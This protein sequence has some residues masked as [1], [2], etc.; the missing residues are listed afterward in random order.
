MFLK[1]NANFVLHL[2]MPG[3]QML[4]VKSR[5]PCTAAYVSSV[6]SAKT[7]VFMHVGPRQA[8]FLWDWH[9]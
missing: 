3:P 7:L 5:S 6:H 9:K 8:T 2:M 4:V 1:Q